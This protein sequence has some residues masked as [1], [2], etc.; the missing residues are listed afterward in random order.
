MEKCDCEK[1]KED[2]E[3]T[4]KNP[5]QYHFPYEYGSHHLR[6]IMEAE[7]YFEER[8]FNCACRKRKIQL[9]EEER[10][11]EPESKR[12]DVSFVEAEDG[13]GSEREQV[14]SDDEEE[15]ED[16]DPEPNQENLPVCGATLDSLLP[17]YEGS[18]S[19]K[20]CDLARASLAEAHVTT[21]AIQLLEEVKQNCSRCLG[22]A[23]EDVICHCAENLE[24][25]IHF[26][27]KEEREEMGWDLGW[28]L[29]E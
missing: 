7:M 26:A 20:I 18:A 4:I 6:D 3:D 23:H 15:K 27:S 12:L 14:E 29:D 19:C 1:A 17:I 24:W 9:Q 8:R 22:S 2:L 11:D 13:S 28:E 5:V 16:S 10:E 21:R 25:V